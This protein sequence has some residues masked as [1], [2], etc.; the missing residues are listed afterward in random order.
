MGIRVLEARLLNYRTPEMLISEDLA[1]ISQSLRGIS[2]A[3]TDYSWTHSEPFR[4]H[5]FFR[6][7]CEGSPRL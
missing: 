3:Q 1:E 5:R 7:A 2:K 4:R 6:G